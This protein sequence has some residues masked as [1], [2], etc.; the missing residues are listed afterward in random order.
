VFRRLLIRLY[1]WL[2]CADPVCDA[3][4]IFAPA[5]RQSRKIY[6]L[7]LFAAGRAPALLFSVG[8]FEIRRFADLSWPVPLDLL[9]IAAPVQPRKRHLFVTYSDRESAVEFI[10]P[11]KFGTLREIYALTAWLAAHRDTNSVLIVSSASHLR[12][13]RM[14]CRSLLPAS[15]QFRLLAVSNDG[16]FLGRETWWREKTAR[17]IVLWELPKL[18]VYWSLLQLERLAGHRLVLLMR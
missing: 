8:R 13:V 10:R 6:A 2:A 12:R 14:C 3:E 5:G 11:G 17:V 4:L 7:E 18:L 1:D 15:I 16:P 9:Q